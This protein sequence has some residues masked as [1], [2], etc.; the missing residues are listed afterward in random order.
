MCVCPY[1]A[2]SLRKAFG[3]LSKHKF[4]LNHFYSGQLISLSFLP[5]H[6]LLGFP[7]AGKHLKD[8]LQITHARYL[9]SGMVY[10]IISKTLREN[11]IKQEL[12]FA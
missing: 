7:H 8:F 1:A 9:Q 10:H 11:L 6:R 4:L 12:V 3:V 2:K 5:V